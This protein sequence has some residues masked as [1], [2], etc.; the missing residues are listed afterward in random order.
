MP[1]VIDEETIIR[2]A[3]RRKSTVFMQLFFPDERKK[4]EQDEDGWT[5]R[6]GTMAYDDDEELDG[7]SGVHYGEETAEPVL[8]G[9]P[10]PRRTEVN[11][12]DQARCC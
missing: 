8:P 6:R 9:L 4:D 2:T 5:M 12:P 7:M 3:S 10:R 11:E 1:A